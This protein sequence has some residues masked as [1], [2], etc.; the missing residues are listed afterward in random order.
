MRSVKEKKVSVGKSCTKTGNIRKGK[1]LSVSQGSTNSKHT[2]VS[3]KTMT[4]K[5]HITSTVSSDCDPTSSFRDDQQLHAIVTPTTYPPPGN[6]YN[7]SSLNNFW[8]TSGGQ[9]PSR[10]LARNAPSANGPQSMYFCGVSL[11]GNRGQICPH[12]LHHRNNTSTAQG[13]GRIDENSPDY[14]GI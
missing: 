11:D 8:N 7:I 4:K 5:S 10:G 3:P 12:F 6:V 2:N 1:R 9:Q 13:G 14:F